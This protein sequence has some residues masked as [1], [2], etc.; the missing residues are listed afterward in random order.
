[1]S[2]NL[3][4]VIRATPAFLARPDVLNA[5]QQFQRR[6]ETVPVAPSSATSSTTLAPRLTALPRTEP[7]HLRRSLAVGAAVGQKTLKLGAGA[8]WT[9]HE[10]AENQIYSSPQPYVSLSVMG[11]EPFKVE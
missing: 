1:M 11:W 9:R 10:T 4:T 7:I 5:T 8:L 2:G 6:L 3:F